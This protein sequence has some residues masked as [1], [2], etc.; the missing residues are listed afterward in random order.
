MLEPESLRRGSLA[1]LLLSAWALPLLGGSSAA[2][3][4]PDRT[5]TPLDGVVVFGNDACPQGAG[6][7]IVVCARQPE[8]ERYRIPKALRQHKAAPITERSWTSRSA[9][10]DAVSQAILP[11]SCSANGSYGQTGCTMQMLRQ[12]AAQ[13]RAA[14][15]ASN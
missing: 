7:E 15:N 14:K 9:S 1:A 4:E 12:W 10:A 11:D 8:S 5:S 2:N 13:R 3:A 6:G